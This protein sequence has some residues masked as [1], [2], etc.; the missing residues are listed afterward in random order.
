MR[1]HILGSL[2][3]LLAINCGCED[4]SQT[5]PGPATLIL[6]LGGGVKMELI[7]IPAG[8]FKMGSHKREKGRAGDEGPQHRVRITKPF[9]M[10]KYEVAQA[11]WIAVMGEDPSRFKGGDLPVEIDWNECDQFCWKVSEIAIKH[12][13]LPTEAEW[14]YACRAGTSTAYSFG[15]S[16]DDLGQYAWYLDNSDSKPHPV[17]QK[18]PNR[19]GFYDMHGNVGEWCQ[20]FAHASYRGA[21]S[22]GSAWA[23]GGSQEFWRVSR[24]GSWSDRGRNCRSAER[25]MRPLDLTYS[26]G[27]RIVVEIQ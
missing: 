9:Y 18:R 16:R 25:I 6:D 12:V 20:D 15:D 2:F 22:D 5:T 1:A 17:G 24:G 13:R 21:P 11:Q 3:V 8:R 14:E 19:W 4:T 7:R 27:L 26:N 23:S 10:G